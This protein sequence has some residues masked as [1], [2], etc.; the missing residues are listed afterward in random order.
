MPHRLHTSFQ[1]EKWQL[2]QQTLG[3]TEDKNKHAKSIYPQNLKIAEK[4]AQNRKLAN[5]FLP[6]FKENHGCITTGGN[7]QVVSGED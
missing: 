2:K 1:Q 6:L 7:N 5:A 3:K 4:P